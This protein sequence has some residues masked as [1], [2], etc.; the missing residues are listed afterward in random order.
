MTQPSQRSLF[1]GKPGYSQKL[2]DGQTQDIIWNLY[3]EFFHH[4]NGVAI[5]DVKD[6]FARLSEMT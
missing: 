1:V 2:K 4:A 6:C 3:E 5:D